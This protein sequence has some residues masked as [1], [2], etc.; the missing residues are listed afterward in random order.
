MK[1][2]SF[3]VQKL[4]GQYDFK[5]D[6]NSDLNILSGR[7]GAGKTTALKLMWYLISGNFDKAVAEIKFKSAKIT[8][9]EYELKVSID[10]NNQEN[11]LFSE[12][13]FF[14]SGGIKVDEKFIEFNKK[15]KDQ[16]VDWFL[17]Q[18]IGSS[19]FFPTFRMIEG[20]FTTEKYDIKHDVLKEFYLKI[21]NNEGGFV[22]IED[23]LKKVS[24]SLN[25]RDHN[26]ITSI[27]ANNIDNLLVKKYASI[28]TDVN[29]NQTELLDS[30]NKQVELYNQIKEVFDSTNSS[31]ST[32]LDQKIVSLQKNIQGLKEKL[33]KIRQPINQVE[34]M[35]SRFFSNKDIIFGGKIQFIPKAVKQE[36]LNSNST[37]D[38]S[39]YTLFT[40]NLSAGEKQ[41]L[42]FISYNAFY[43]NSIFFID[44]PELSLHA[45][46]QRIL[47]RML[48]QQNSTNQFIISTHS[49][50]I[51]SKYP[52]KEICIDPEQ[53]R[54]NVED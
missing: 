5:K 4:F 53:N 43:D 47:F 22:E 15:I 1:I 37:I 12:I 38:I 51:Y 27:S 10:L 24:N 19:F 14:N 23:A 48:K 29:T 40:N 20:G 34:K 33:V 52:D 26:F 13:S 25:N 28:I 49:P 16:K 30:L 36:L 7:N 2:K 21:N 9:D 45:D 17:T 50:F 3:E 32:S 35:V 39:K 46:W 41:L 31:E 8:T 18:Y 44:E 54:G 6:F 42:T 11:P